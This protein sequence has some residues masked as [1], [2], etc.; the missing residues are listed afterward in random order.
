[1]ESESQESTRAVMTPALWQAM[2]QSKHAKQR[3]KPRGYVAAQRKARKTA[4]ASRAANRR[5]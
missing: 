3:R 2:H 4:H 5:P 1:M